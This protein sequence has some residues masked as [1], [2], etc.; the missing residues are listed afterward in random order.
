MVR[1]RKGGEV[2]AETA[3]WGWRRFC[4]I[5]QPEKPGGEG[6]ARAEQSKALLSQAPF[7]VRST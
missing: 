2:G 4:I 3:G 7:T 5:K 6:G 1:E